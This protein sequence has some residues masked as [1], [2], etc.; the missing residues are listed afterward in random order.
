MVELSESGRR[1]IEALLGASVAWQSPEELAEATGGELEATLDA[2]ATLD[3]DGW[4]AAW[5]RGD[6]LVVTL[7]VGAVSALEVRLVE[8]GPGQVPRWAG[9]SE[10]DPEPPRASGVFR[11]DRAASL[12]LVV[13][14]G[15]S[16]EEAAGLAEARS[17]RVAPPGAR[18]GPIAIELLPRPTRFLGTSTTPWPGPGD[19]RKASCPVCGSKRLDPATYCLYCDR[20][21][22]DHL[23]RGEPAPKSRRRRR[24]PEADLRRAERER[25][26]RKAKHQ[27]RLAARADAD[28]R[29]GPSRRGPRSPA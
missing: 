7:S 26:A 4:L 22:L 13:D 15:I 12:E 27:D 2:L 28:R 8:V 29:P 1:L 20:W 17:A 16:P 25:Q 24:D 21:G 11:A 5:P 23:V 18:P 19:G 6:G 14:P 10:P 9:A 3:A